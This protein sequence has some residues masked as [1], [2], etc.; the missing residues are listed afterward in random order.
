[1]HPSTASS[2]ARRLGSAA[3]DDGVLGLA[4]L[5]AHGLSLDRLDQRPPQQPEPCLVSCPR[6]T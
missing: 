3:G 4:Y 6:I 5:A 1:M 2:P